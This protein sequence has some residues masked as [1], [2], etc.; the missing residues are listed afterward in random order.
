MHLSGYTGTAG[1]SML[2]NTGNTVNNVMFSTADKDNDKSNTNCYAHH[3]YGGWWFN[4]CGQANLNSQ[5]S[6]PTNYKR[7]FWYT[8]K[9]KYTW[10]NLTE[11]KMRKQ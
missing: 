10:M 9:P 11:M 6:S 7:P 3:G 5:W 8:F 4:A 1:D 2:Y